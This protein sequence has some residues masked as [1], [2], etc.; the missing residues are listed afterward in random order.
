M[1]SFSSISIIMYNFFY[2][3]FSLSNF[4]QNFFEGICLK[5]YSHLA[6]NGGVAYDM[7]VFGILQFYGRYLGDLNKKWSVF[8]ILVPIMVMVIYIFK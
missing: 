4:S 7:A 5:F 3:L 1:H 8:G 6:H 2:K